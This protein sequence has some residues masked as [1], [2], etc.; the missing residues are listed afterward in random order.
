MASVHGRSAAGRTFELVQATVD[1][2]AVQPVPARH[3][4]AAMI[5]IQVATA[6]VSAPSS[7]APVSQISA[8]STERRQVGARAVPS[9]S[10]VPAVVDRDAAS[11]QPSSL[12]RVERGA[13]HSAAQFQGQRYAGQ[14]YAVSRAS[15]VLRPWYGWTPPIGREAV[16]MWHR[17]SRRR[18]RDFDDPKEREDFLRQEQVDALILLLPRLVVAEMMGGERGLQQVADPARREAQ[19]RRK[20]IARAGS[21]GSQIGD[22]RTFLRKARAYAQEVMRAAPGTEDEALWPMS[23]SLADDIVA[24][25]HARA[26]TAGRGSQGGATQGASLRDTIVFA[27]QRMQWPISITKGGLDS[28]APPAAGHACPAAR[29][30]G[31]GEI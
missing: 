19:L 15:M 4:H 9:F 7:M 29:R 8:A 24:D 31:Q 20:F 5:Q 18:P 21:E 23:E 11:L 12:V 25:E 13:R 2:G 28:A 1:R 27:A 3:T 17:K 22:L 10:L 6:P 14:T 30:G 26:T 16:R